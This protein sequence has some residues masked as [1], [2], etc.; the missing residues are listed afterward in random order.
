MIASY[1]LA[2]YQ[3]G[4]LTQLDDWLS[5][6]LESTTSYGV[7]LGLGWMKC[8]IKL[9]SASLGIGWGRG[10]AELGNNTKLGLL[11]LELGLNVSLEGA[12]WMEQKRK[13]NKAQIQLGLHAA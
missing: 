1:Q 2:S 12:G 10:L 6:S 11:E 3:L 7:G 4:L 5:C 13:Y 8:K 9:S